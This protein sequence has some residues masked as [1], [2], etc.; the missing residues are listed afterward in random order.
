[1]AVHLIQRAPDDV[2]AD[3]RMTDTLGIGRTA[4]VLST[5]RLGQPL[6]V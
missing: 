6:P 5:R 3:V 4:L 1:M 2:V